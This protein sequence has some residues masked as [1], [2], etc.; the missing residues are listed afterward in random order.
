M[1]RSH[2]IPEFVFR[3]LYDEAHHFH[4]VSLIPGENDYLGQKGLWERLLCQSFETKISRWER[5]ASLLFNG[6]RPVA[7]ERKMNLLFVQGVDA[8]AFRLFLLSVPCLS[9]C[10]PNALPVVG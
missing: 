3:A 4:V 9:G 8:V 7:V 2:V 5:Y 6:G 10:H 1:R